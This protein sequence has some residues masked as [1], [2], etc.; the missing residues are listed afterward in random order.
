MSLFD[1]YPNIVLG[2]KSEYGYCRAS[3]ANQYNQETKRIG[4]QIT[5]RKV[6]EI[7]IHLAP[8]GLPVTNECRS[9]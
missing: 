8:S 7:P 9:V 1:K 3:F 4:K 5:R 2:G 6:K